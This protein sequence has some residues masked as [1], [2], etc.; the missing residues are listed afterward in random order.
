MSDGTVALGTRERFMTRGREV[1]PGVLTAGMIGMAAAFLSEHYGAPVML[2][3]LL[4]G[5]AFH[6]L[7][8]ETRCTAGIEFSARTILRIGVAL[9]GSRITVEQIVG[10]GT[11]PVITVIAGI[12]LTIGF[13]II[14]ARW[15]KLDGA[16]GAL[17]GG[18]VAI[19]GAS[20]ALA[21]SAVLPRSRVSERDIIFTVISVTSLSTLVMIIYPMLIDFLHLDLTQDGILIGA[22]IHDVAQVVGAGYSISDTT[23]DVAT[24]TKLMRVALLAPVVLCFTF[25]FGSKE[26]TEAKPKGIKR[27]FPL[28]FFL[29]AFLVIMG[30]NSTGAIPDNVLTGMTDAS[31]WCLV[32]AIAALGMKTSLKT[33]AEVGLKPVFLM[34]METVFIA[35]VAVT[36]VLSSV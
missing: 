32:T 30:I 36:I 9:L 4:L 34:V 2:F 8:Q 31:R 18:A 10:L 21:I 17:T 33:L 11:L 23:G 35:A 24:Y 25:A 22:T 5:M 28:P 6:F 1:F 27:L 16:L 20:A 13:G 19:C 3:A 12:V 15:M 26:E 7:S 14:L 29:I